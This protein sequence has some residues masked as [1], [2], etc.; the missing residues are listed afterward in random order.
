VLHAIESWSEELKGCFVV[1]HVDNTSDVFGFVKESS[2]SLR[3]LAIIQEVVFR[4]FMKYDITPW[5]EFVNS[6]ENCAD[7][8][9]RPDLIAFAYYF[10]RAQRSVIAVE[11]WSK[12]LSFKPEAFCEGLAM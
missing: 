9:S 5:W 1:F 4:C 10:W 6:K 3:T 11:D 7:A 12:F 8:F 2:K